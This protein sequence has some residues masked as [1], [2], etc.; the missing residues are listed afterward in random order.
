MASPDAADLGARLDQDHSPETNGRMRVCRRCGART[1]DT[2]GTRHLPD[3]HRLDR[4][5][6][7]LDAQERTRRCDRAR[8]SMKTSEGRNPAKTPA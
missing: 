5:E 6:Q 3:E 1:D 2:Q 4:G 8:A 7:W